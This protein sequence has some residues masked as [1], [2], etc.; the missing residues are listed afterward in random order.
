MRC[1]IPLYYEAKVLFIIY[2]WHPKTKGAQFLYSAYVQ[3]FLAGH[4]ATIDQY[5]Q[6]VKTWI[7][8]LLV[9]HFQR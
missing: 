4:E 9:T 8:D 7:S 5:T 1:R 6:E 3:P 2:L